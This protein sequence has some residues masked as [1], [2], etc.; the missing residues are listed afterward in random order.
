[1]TAFPTFLSVI[2]HVEARLGMHILTFEYE[3]LSELYHYNTRTA[4]QLATNCRASSTAFFTILKKLEACG[5][6]ASEPDEN[7]KRFRRYHISGAAM[8]A[9]DQF[10]ILISQWMV[11]KL[12]NSES[13]SNAYY[14]YIFSIK[15]KINVRVNTCEYQIIMYLYDRHHLTNIE[16]NNIVDVSVTK[17]NRCLKKLEDSGLIFSERNH[18]DKR[19]KLYHLSDDTKQIIDEAHMLMLTWKTGRSPCPDL[20]DLKASIPDMPF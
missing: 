6:I 10:N 18:E 4:Q 12:E 20:E 11:S 17:F 19:S 14:N 16:F 1:M 3:I 15:E 8:Q 13:F 7:D 5:I 2:R 9:I